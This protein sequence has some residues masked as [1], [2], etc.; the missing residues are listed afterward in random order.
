MA[1]PGGAV[2]HVPLSRGEKAG[3]LGCLGVVLL[4]I[5]L[6]VVAIHLHSEGVDLI[7]TRLTDEERCFARGEPLVGHV[8]DEI[9]CEHVDLT[10]TSGDWRPRCRLEIEQRNAG[11]GHVFGGYRWFDS[12]TARV[13]R[14]KNLTYCDG[15]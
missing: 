5:V 14:A 6:V 12:E 9:Q 4:P 8:G 15:D 10:T 1:E 7:P 13:E 3:C 11:R 2:E